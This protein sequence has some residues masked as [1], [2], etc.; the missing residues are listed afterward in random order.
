MITADFIPEIEETERVLAVDHRTK[1]LYPTTGPEDGVTW[2]DYFRGI[3]NAR[4][5]LVAEAKGK[6]DDDEPEEKIAVLESAH[7]IDYKTLSARSAPAQLAKRLTEAGWTVRVQMSR[8][9]V[10]AVLYINGSPEGTPPE[11]YHSAGD[12]RYPE[13]ELETWCVLGVKRMPSGRLGF[14]CEATWTS[15][16]GF[17]SAETHDP[18][19]K[20]ERRTTSLKPRKP[21]DWE[22]E[23]GITGP[24]GLNQWLAIVAPKPEPKKKMKEA[25]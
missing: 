4:R 24:L 16:Q 5:A 19:L 20:R 12:V 25:A 7:D 1:P 15:K 6:S 23:E 3:G 18:I 14:A 21:R 2:E 8:V 13:H 9:R 10:A 22:K 17:V 11:K